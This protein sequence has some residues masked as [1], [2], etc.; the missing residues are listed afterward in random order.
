MTVRMIQASGF[1]VVRL[2]KE[3]LHTYQRVESCFTKMVMLLWQHKRGFRPV[4]MG[5]SENI[6]HTFIICN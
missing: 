3:I 1:L 5:L 6:H 4:S 2:F